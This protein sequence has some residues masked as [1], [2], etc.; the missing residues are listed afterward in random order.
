MATEERD[1]AGLEQRP[2]WFAP[3]ALEAAELMSDPVVR[4]V[5]IWWL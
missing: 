3:S 4:P 2:A 5:T 1:R